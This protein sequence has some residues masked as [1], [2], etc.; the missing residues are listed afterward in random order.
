MGGGFYGILAPLCSACSCWVETCCCEVLPQSLILVQVSDFNSIPPHHICHSIISNPI[1]QIR[2]RYQDGRCV[3]VPK[4]P[5]R[6]MNISGSPC[7][8]RTAIADAAAMNEH[9]D[10]L[11]GDW[12]SELNMPTRAYNLST[13]LDTSV[14]YEE[15]FLEALEFALADMARKGIR[16]AAKAGCVATEAL[17]E[18]VLKMVK[19]KGLSLTVAWIEGDVVVDLVKADLKNNPEKFY[20]ISTRKSLA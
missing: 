8:K 15:T 19:A 6:I 20:R 12:M 4:R 5:V 10:V 7:D 1:A 11:V 14:E 3:P 2:S 17:Y 16:L 13:S 9:I 18:E